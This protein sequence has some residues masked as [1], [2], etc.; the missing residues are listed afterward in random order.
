M[1]ELYRLS[2]RGQTVQSKERNKNRDLFNLWLNKNIQLEISFGSYIGITF[3]HKQ[4]RIMQLYLTHTRLLSFPLAKHTHTHTHTTHT[5]T[6]N[7]K[8]DDQIIKNHKA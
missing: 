1:Q 5:G 8:Q 4:C 3:K 2:S 6:E 7:R